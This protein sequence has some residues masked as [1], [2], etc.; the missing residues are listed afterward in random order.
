MPSKGVKVYGF[1][2]VPD[3]AIEYSVPGRIVKCDQ[4]GQ[5]FQDQLEVDKANLKG[6]FNFTGRFTFKVTHAGQ[7]LTNQWVD[8]NALTGH[9]SNGTMNALSHS[10][11]IVHDQ[12]IICY[13]LYDAGSGQA[14]LPSQDQCYVTV[15]PNRSNWMEQLVPRGSP[16][17][18][19]SFSKMVLP[20]V[21]DVGMNSL[22]NALALL[23][24]AGD[25]VIRLALKSFN[26]DAD[27]HFGL[28]DSAITHIAPNIIE[29]LSITQKDSLD[30]LLAIGARYFEFR[31]AK[32]YQKFKE[33]MRLADALY[34]QHACIPGLAMDEFLHGIVEFLRAHPF[35]II[36][37]QVRY[38]GVMDGCDRPDAAAL[39][40]IV[41]RA[42]EGSG[43]QRGRLPDLTA[44]IHDLRVSGKRLIFMNPVPSFSTYTDPGNA[45]L[46]GDSIVAEFENLNI[47]QQQGNNAFVNI[48]CQA[49][50]TNVKDAVIYSALSANASNSCLM[51][52]KAICDS[53]TLPWLKQH[54][55]ER[56]AP[57]KL[58]VIMN[59]FLDGATAD[60][61]IGLCKQRLE[62]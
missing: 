3:C 44:T 2:A 4:L 23:Q 18:E 30:T 60:V 10:S 59:D 9:I 37:V 58:V 38:D 57:D 15:T 32:I 62:A 36:V 21:H 1:V 22:Q 42:L 20:A 6:P 55:A 50:A 33:K 14:G 11:S 48:Q 61:A 27:I 39:D 28:A 17:I 54:G 52:T 53:K 29:S 13:G 24:D 31:P 35:E 40:D 7:E 5:F 12:I 46:T 34:F 43:L 47:E 41:N 49:T 25:Q 56:L 45:T 8:I 16:G 51:A 19:K 26:I